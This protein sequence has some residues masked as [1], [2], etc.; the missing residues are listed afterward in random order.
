MKEFVFENTRL[1]V[2]V[3]RTRAWYDAHDDLLER[4][5]CAYCRN[6]RAAQAYL[7]EEADHFLNT[8]GLTL[9]KPAEVMEWC[10]EA[11]GRHWY[12]LQ[13]HLVGE[14]LEKGDAPIPL[15][16]EVTAGFTVDSGPF[17][18]NFPTPFFQLF[19]DIRLPWVLKESDD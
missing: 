11:D 4:C 6:F 5:S 7:P 2:D 14:L 17:L 9:Q 12:T 8:M 13:Y 18:E 3:E 15:A 16:P 10:K 1:Q 19:L